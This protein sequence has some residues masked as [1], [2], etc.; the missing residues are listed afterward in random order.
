VIVQRVD[1]EYGE[2]SDNAI[3]II[4][5]RTSFES[6]KEKM[7]QSVFA[8]TAYESNFVKNLQNTIAPKVE[9]KFNG[10]NQHE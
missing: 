3:I 10:M 4:G 5:M 8:E 1:R 7:N 9:K 6:V 2:V